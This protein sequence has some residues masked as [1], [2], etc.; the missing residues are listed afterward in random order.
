METRYRVRISHERKANKV[1][2]ILV[3]PDGLVD[4][5]VYIGTLADCYAYVKIMEEKL[6][7]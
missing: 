3:T 1:I 6:W 7:E 2:R 5:V 4:S